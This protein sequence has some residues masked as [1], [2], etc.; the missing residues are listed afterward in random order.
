VENDMKVQT[1]GI[2]IALASA[3]AGGLLPAAVAEQMIG[4]YHMAAG[5]GA[6]ALMNAAIAMVHIGAPAG[7]DRA[8]KNA[9]EA[10]ASRNPVAMSM[11]NVELKVTQ[12]SGGAPSAQTK[13]PKEPLTF[14]V[15]G[16]YAPP[17]E[18]EELPLDVAMKKPTKNRA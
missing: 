7:S 6:V 9:H 2:V 8:H 10:D 14:P 13:S 15:L 11:G 16:W 5:L 17:A 4:T 1:K 12:Q 3:A 18:V